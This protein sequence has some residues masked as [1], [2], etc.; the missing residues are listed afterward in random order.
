MRVTVLNHSRDGIVVHKP[1]C[2]DIAKQVRRR[3]VNSDWPVD[4]PDGTEVA[5]AVADNLNASF[6][7]PYDGDPDEPA[8]W[9]ARNIRVLPC[10]GRR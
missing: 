1:G 7:W 5:T 2:A 8:P 3:E 10:V 4:V 9:A 6:G